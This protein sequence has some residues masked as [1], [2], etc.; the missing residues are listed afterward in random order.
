[1]KPA[2][3]DYHAPGSLVE[4]LDLIAEHGDEARVLA[5]G[6]SLV[7]MLNMRLIRPRVLVSLRRL[8]ELDFVR[9]QDGTVVVGSMTRQAAL[10]ASPDV[11]EVSVVSVLEARGPE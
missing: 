1:M 5:G 11:R 3:F 9:R 2:P 6:Q 8:R 10:E 7:P 4:A